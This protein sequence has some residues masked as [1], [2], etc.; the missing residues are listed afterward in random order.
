MPTDTIR[1]TLFV[2]G[3]TPN[4]AQAVDNLKSLC[5]RYLPLRHEIEVVD[6]FT[7]PARAVAEGVRLT[8]TVL[9]RPPAPPLRIVGTLADQDEVFAGMADDTLEDALP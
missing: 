6:V 3:R 8:P 5:R 1:F 4:S 9:R 2:A 7:E